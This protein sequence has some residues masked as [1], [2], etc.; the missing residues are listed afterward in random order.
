MLLGPGSLTTFLT[1]PAAGELSNLAERP[2]A[3]RAEEGWGRGWGD[4]DGAGVDAAFSGGPVVKTSFAGWIPACG[5]KIPQV[6][7]VKCCQEI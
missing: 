2:D 4:G 7:T 5:P 6:S 1:G 3:G